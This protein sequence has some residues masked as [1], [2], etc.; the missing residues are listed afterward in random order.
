MDEQN[1]TPGPWVVRRDGKKR[2]VFSE[3]ADETVAW[4]KP[5]SEIADEADAALIAA[6]P[7]LLEALREILRHEVYTYEGGLEARI[8]V[9]QDAIDSAL[10]AIAKA[11][12]LS[13]SYP[14]GGR[15]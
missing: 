8:T 1:H 11:A 10:A 14:A 5:W 13:E 9:P 4:I 12:P 6:A 15:E 7:D 3:A 2:S